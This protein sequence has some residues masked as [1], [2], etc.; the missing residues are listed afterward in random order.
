MKIY[1]LYFFILIYVICSNFA[2]AQTKIINFQLDGKKYET[3][4][5]RANLYGLKSLYTYIKGLSGDGY[6][7]RFNIP[8]SIASHTQWYDIRT[9]EYDPAQK[10]IFGINMAAIL[11]NDTIDGAGGRLLLHYDEKMPTLKMKYVKSKIFNVPSY[12]ITDSL[13]MENG[14]LIFDQFLLDPIV[15]GSDFEIELENPRI[16]T[17]YLYNDNHTFVYL[18][19]SLSQKYPDSRYL[20]NIASIYLV[21]RANN[22]EGKK[23]YNNFSKTNRDTYWGERM[24]KYLHTFEFKNMKLPVTNNLDKE[25]LIITDSEKYNLIVF[26]ASWCGPCIEEIPILKE[27]YNDL[28]ENL[29]IIYVSIDEKKTVVAWQN[30]IQTK[31]IPWRSLNAY[32]NIDEVQQQYNLVFGIPYNLLV[33][34]N[35]KAELI[36]IR[37]TEDRQQLYH[38]MNIIPN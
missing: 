16:S 26:S 6:N 10:Q 25:E 32:K 37:K 24:L 9:R 18:L 34:P 1:Q 22:I 21:S 5:L 3:M 30:L 19:D 20:M 36:D 23:I 27:I 2:S 15:N 4:Y 35:G 14:Q 29:N 17:P 13:F 28:K 8:D 12:R 11:R 7:W 31:S 38:L 33:T